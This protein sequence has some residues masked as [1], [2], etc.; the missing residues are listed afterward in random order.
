MTHVPNKHERAPLRTSRPP[1]HPRYCTLVFMGTSCFPTSNLLTKRF[2]AV[3]SP[4][5][6]EAAGQH[7]WPFANT[8][9]RQVWTLTGS[10][11]TILTTAGDSE[12]P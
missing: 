11:F 1:C 4:L 8:S 6:Q 3:L 10:M 9:R 5:L 2:L 7:A 12:G